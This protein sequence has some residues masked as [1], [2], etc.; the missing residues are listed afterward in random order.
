M[1]HLGPLP[2]TP[3]YDTIDGGVIVGSS[4]KLDGDTWNPVD[5]PRVTEF[6]DAVRAARAG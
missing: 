3:L 2:G 5:P 4:L 1:A 6:M